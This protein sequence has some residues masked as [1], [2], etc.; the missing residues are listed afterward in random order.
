MNPGVPSPPPSAAWDA[1][2]ILRSAG[3]GLGSFL[4][5]IPP[6]L[7]NFF[8]GVAA[9]AG[10]HGVVDWAAMLFGLALLL[11]AIRG[12]RRRRIVGPMVGG[13][14]GVALMGWAIA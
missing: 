10:L 5:G 12:F 9:G 6:A 8:S 7:V 13:A 14:I 4:A 3:E 11:S 1:G 2:D